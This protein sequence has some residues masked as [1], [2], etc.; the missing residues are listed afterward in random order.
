VHAGFSDPGGPSRV[1]Q[2]GWPP[3]SLADSVLPYAL[4]IASASTMIRISGL[5]LLSSHFPLSTLRDR[6]TP[7]VT[8]DSLPAGDL[9]LAGQGSNLQGS[10]RWF[11]HLLLHLRP[12]SPG[13]SWRTA[14]FDPL[15]EHLEH[16][17]TRDQRA[18]RN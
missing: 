14:N 6:V 5:I 9:S 13:L 8:Q 15:T 16:A 12:P 3:Y 17:P 4:A 10:Y 2:S 7:V 11:L 1:G 18:E